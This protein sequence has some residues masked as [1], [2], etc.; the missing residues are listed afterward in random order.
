MAENNQNFETLKQGLTAYK[1]YELKSLGT[2]ISKKLPTRKAELVDHI[3]KLVFS[4]LNDIVNELD[5]L[6][7]AAL[8]EA[9][10][11]WNGEFRTKQFIA[12]YGA[13]PIQNTSDDPYRKDLHLLFL[14]F[15]KGGIPIDLQDRLKTILHQ[16]ETESIQYSSQEDLDALIV[17]ETELA[18]AMN[19]SMMIDM[20]N[21][22]KLKVSAKTGRPT[23]A[24]IKKSTQHCMTVIFMKMTNMVRF[25]LLHGR[26]F[27]KAAAWRIWTGTH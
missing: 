16:P 13:Y 22:G 23:A 12:K 25:N 5:E 1:V 20:V 7:V 3:N 4:N 27:F 14:F 6:G 2:L 10:F 18:A 26:F 15:I 11:N 24:T 9:V 17:R 19:L 8:E 21:D